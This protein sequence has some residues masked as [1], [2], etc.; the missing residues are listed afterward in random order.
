MFFVIFIH[1]KGRRDFENQLNV[2][3]A[4]Q[5]KAEQRRLSG[6]QEVLEPGPDWPVFRYHP[7]PLHTGSIIESTKICDSCNTARGFVYIHH[8]F[9]R[10]RSM[11]PWCISSGLA[12]EKLNLYFTPVE[13]VGGYGVWSDV[14]DEVKQEIAYRTPGFQ[15]WQHE[16]WWTHC[17][18][19]A[20]Y[21]GVADKNE[22][23]EC[24][25]DLIEMLKSQVR[26]EDWPALLESFEHTGSPTAYVFQC[27]H[28]GQY[29]GYWDCD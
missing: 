11:C 29:G 2:T 27:L 7:N 22:I 21:L 17:G 26:E 3:R 16:Q 14:S 8:F 6:V 25:S 1:I 20:A 9:G 23:V 12:F 19:A 10:E 13:A 24:G 5:A 18:D 28:C 15:G 4:R